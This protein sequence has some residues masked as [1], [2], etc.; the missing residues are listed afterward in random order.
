[1]KFKNANEAFE[2][3]YELINKEGV[4]FANT[5][6]LFNQ[7]FYIEKPVDNNILSSFR[8]WN[9]KYAEY[10]WQWYLNANPNAEEIS[11][12]APIWISHMDKNGDVRSNYGWQWNREDQLTKV[13]EKLKILDNRQAVLSFYDGKEIDT[14]EYDTPCTMSVHFQVINKELC[15]TVNMR[16]NDLWFGF[17]ND[18]YCFSRLQEVI[19]EKLNVK[20]G[21][22]YHFASNL[23]VYFDKLNKKK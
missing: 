12:R 4:L 1:M 7:G 17:C 16:S 2:Y 6:A 21:W 19:A 15:M 13:I 10:E 20:I 14:Y 5:K 3:Y 18:Q 9:L 23:H 22:Y 11:K 8:N